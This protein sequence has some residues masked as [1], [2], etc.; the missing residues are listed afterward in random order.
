[1]NGARSTH[2]SYEKFI[3][4]ISQKDRREEIGRYLRRLEDNI[5]MYLKEKEYL[6]ED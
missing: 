3:Q 5:D 6:G 4:H 2:G 1:M